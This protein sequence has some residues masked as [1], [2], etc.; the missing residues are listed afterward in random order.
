MP[1]RNGL[2]YHIALLFF[3]T[4]LARPTAT[5]ALSLAQA[6]APAADLPT[7]YDLSIR[8]S[9]SREGYFVLRL[10]QVPQQSLT[11]EQSRHADFRTIE[12]SFPW[13]GDFQQMTLSGFADGQYYFRVK[14]T[15]GVTSTTARLE[16]RHYPQWQAYSLFA[17]GLVLFSCLV[18]C[19]LVFSYRSRRGV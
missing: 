7:S 13:F 9:L 17:L 5:H 11:I 6:K 15:D 3:I 18:T 10:G 12:A 4:L 14:P 1:I 16:V 19:I 2:I 8:P